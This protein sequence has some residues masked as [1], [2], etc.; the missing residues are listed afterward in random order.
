MALVKNTVSG[1]YIR[2]LE[3]ESPGVGPRNLSFNQV[4]FFYPL[5]LLTTVSADG[6]SEKGCLKNP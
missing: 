2:P 1:L 6:E 5:V 4:G 3:R